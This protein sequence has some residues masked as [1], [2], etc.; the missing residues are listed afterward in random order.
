MA[1]AKEC[2]VCGQLYKDKTN[3]SNMEVN[4]ID[5]NG[6]IRISILFKTSDEYLD[7]CKACKRK[8]ALQLADFYE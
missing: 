6:P 7:I 4:L 3:P 5:W 2:D 8:Y 1:D